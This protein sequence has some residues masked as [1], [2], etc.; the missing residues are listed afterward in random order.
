MTTRRFRMWNA[1]G[2]VSLRAVLD[3]IDGAGLIWIIEFF[4]GIGRP[5]SRFFSD[6]IGDF[7]QY[8]SENDQGFQVSWTE[9]LEF[10]EGI[11]WG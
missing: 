3:D 4:D 8:L 5:P 1:T 7:E 6:S 11:Q 2:K 10:A 9:L